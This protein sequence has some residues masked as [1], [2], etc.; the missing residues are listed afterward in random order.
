MRITAE[1]SRSD[2]RDRGLLQGPT[3]YSAIEKGESQQ[4]TS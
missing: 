3:A 2:S 4:T 1:E